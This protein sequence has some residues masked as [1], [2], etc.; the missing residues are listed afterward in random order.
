MLAPSWALGFGKVKRS[1]SNFEM[2]W[3]GQKKNPGLRRGSLPKL[4]DQLIGVSKFL[5]VGFAIGVSVVSRGIC[6]YARPNQ[7]IT[8]IAVLRVG[9]G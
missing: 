8:Q 6:Y 5:Q 7:L 4:R 1:S 9:I 3:S 2:S